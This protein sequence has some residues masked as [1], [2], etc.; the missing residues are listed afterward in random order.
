MPHE[1][2]IEIR[3]ADMDAFGHV[4]NATYLTYLEE[5]RD[6]WIERA[7]GDAGD[8]EDFVL[9]RVA[10]DY[11]REL[12]QLDDAVIATCRLDRLGRS[13]VHTAEEIRTAAGE[14]AARAASVMVP[15]DRSTGSARRLTD[16]E[17]E[18]LSG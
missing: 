4:N 1:K 3:W 7:L 6:E 17:R 12:T 10:I 16:V 13:S 8:L 11:Y 9:A 15:R 5:V 18:A 14:M 2:R